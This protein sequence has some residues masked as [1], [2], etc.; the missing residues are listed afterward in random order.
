M[1]ARLYVAALVAVLTL[2]CLLLV[3]NGKHRPHIRPVLP[4]GLH[5]SGPLTL[6]GDPGFFH[7]QAADAALGHSPL[8]TTDTPTATDP[9]SAPALVAGV[10]ITRPLWQDLSSQQQAV[11]Q[12]LQSSWPYLSNAEK[13][14]WLAVAQKAR[15]LDAAAVDLLAER[16]SP[17]S[18][19][20][21]NERIGIR[22][23][24]DE[25]Q[26]QLQANGASAW[27]VYS[28]LSD[29]EKALWV[30]RATRQSAPQAAQPSRR[31]QR[32]PLV[33]I[34]AANQ[35]R[36]QLANLPKIPLE[37]V[38]LS[39]AQQRNPHQPTST[40]APVA[41]SNQPAPSTEKA[42]PA[43]SR[44]WGTITITPPDPLPP[45]YEN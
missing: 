8:Q 2:L 40:V 41:A 28:Q 12:S 25:Q 18:R 17:W 29:I 33:R 9:G 32:K 38:V 21:E 31:T 14:R 4:D 7:Q 34:P 23:L 19:L 1:S 42:A 39:P 26:A 22:R 16:I 13:R 11:L 5:Y 20:D 6:F 45:A 37:P 27:Q 24:F 15:Q 3:W 30:R 44:R 10:H 35:A 43:S 36:R